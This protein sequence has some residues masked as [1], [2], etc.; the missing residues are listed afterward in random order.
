MLRKWTVLGGTLAAVTAL[1]V[2][3]SM[4]DDDEGPLHQLMEKV[5]KHNAVITKGARTAVNYKKA[6][7]EVFASAEELVKLAKEAKPLKDGIKKAKGL[8]DAQGK[9]D[10]YMDDFEKSSAAL[11][12]V[13]ASPK[14]NNEE[15]K[16]AHGVV[17]A[18]CAACHKDFKVE[19]E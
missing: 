19:D 8:A 1:T 15:A 4:A 13:A 9:W 6:Q 10:K 17:K 7:K 3:I 5:Q 12:K 16:K 11:A 14:S 2:G 18:A